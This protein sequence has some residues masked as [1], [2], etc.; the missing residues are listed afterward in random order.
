[1]I[2]YL[3]FKNARIPLL[4]CITIL[5]IGCTQSITTDD[6]INDQVIE[7]EVIETTID[8]YLVIEAL[9]EEVSDITWAPSSDAYTECDWGNSCTYSSGKL[10]SKTSW[11]YGKFEIRA[12]I[13]SANIMWPAIWML[14]VAEQTTDETI[15]PYAGEIDIMEYFGY[16]KNEL[17]GSVHTT[18]NNG[19]SAPS[20]AIIDTTGSTDFHLYI[21]IWTETR[22]EIYLD[23]TNDINQ[24]I[25]VWDFGTATD[26]NGD[27]YDDNYPFTE[28]FYL[29][30]NLAVGG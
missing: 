4:L 30:L 1:M 8:G 23:D 20:N 6:T 7:D 27:G 9:P 3:K 29:I 12:R 2:S 15:W 25:L 19:G 28:P 11:T 22:I 14:P 21:L 17:R 24:R 13:P 5:I 10:K 16:A 18:N 26:T